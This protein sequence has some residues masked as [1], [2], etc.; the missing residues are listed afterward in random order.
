MK[1]LFGFNLKA[2]PCPCSKFVSTD[3]QWSHQ[4]FMD[5]LLSPAP[6]GNPKSVLTLDVTSGSA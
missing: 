6:G 4:T 5:L 1:M 2:I 3:F